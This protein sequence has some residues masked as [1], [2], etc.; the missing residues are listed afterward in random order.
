MTKNRLRLPVFSVCFFSR[1]AQGVLSGNK[2]DSGVARGAVFLVMMMLVGWTG[3]TV[4][5][6]IVPGVRSSATT[7]VSKDSQ[8]LDELIAR[9]ESKLKEADY[10]GARE[11]L[12]K[13]SGLAEEDPR[14]IE[15]L[16]AVALLSAEMQWWRFA[17]SN[18][19]ANAK[20]RGVALT[21][22]QAAAT[23]A[24]DRA[25]KA[26]AKLG[27]TAAALRL[28]LGRQRLD[29]MLVYALAHSGEMERAKAVLAARKPT[30]P[31]AAL[32]SKLVQ[33]PAPSAAPTDSA[34][35]AASKAKPV[36]AAGAR[37]PGGG[38]AA[39]AAKEYEFDDE[40]VLKGPTT[41]GELQLPKH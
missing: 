5:E 13:A 38:P 30:H 24:L 27:K 40:P 33:R 6:R 1:Y 37:K 18:A 10:E 21:S 34:K 7:A 41:P 3:F 17:L 23:K 29:A 8:R 20:Q 4:Y 19:A 28:A 2:K 35:P 22:L 9:A 32:L 36:A 11:Q 39:W 12:T 15:G 31:E 26:E 25:A 14:V 16:A